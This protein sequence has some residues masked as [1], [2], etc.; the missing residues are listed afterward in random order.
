[1]ATA[2]HVIAGH[3]LY[4][5]SVR[6]DNLTIS[7]RLDAYHRWAVQWH[8]RYRTP[9]W[10]AETSN[11]GLPVDDQVPWFEAFTNRLQLMAADG[12]PVRGICWYS[13]GD[14]FDW[15]TALTE[16]TG[17]L[18]E[19]GLYSQTRDPRAITAALQNTIEHA[20]GT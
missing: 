15:Q 16:P 5:V 17:A 19:V 8:D 10:I 18:T 6:S 4:P 14:Q 9:F 11:L 20:H 3:D 1:M 13:R 12:L 2:E 7:D